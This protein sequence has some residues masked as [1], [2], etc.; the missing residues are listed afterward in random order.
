MQNKLKKTGDNHS[1]LRLES[2]NLSPSENILSPFARTL[3][4]SD[5]GQR[6]FFKSPFKSSNGISY[7]YSGTKY[8]ED[9]I[10]IGEN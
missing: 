5:M 1:R 8:I 9:I 6:Y 10:N 2:I 7:S 3:L 4:S